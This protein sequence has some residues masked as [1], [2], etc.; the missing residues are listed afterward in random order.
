MIFMLSVIILV[1]L[2]EVI[3]QLTVRIL[4]IRDGMSLMTLMLVKLIHLKLLV[5]QLMCYFTDV[6]K[7]SNEVKKEFIAYVN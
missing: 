6:G 1:A 4:L 2:M 5:K 3:T 7:I